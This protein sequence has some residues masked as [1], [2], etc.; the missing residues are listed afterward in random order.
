M[1]LEAQYLIPWR[2]LKLLSGL[3]GVRLMATYAQKYPMK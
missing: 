3:A 2:I 1:D